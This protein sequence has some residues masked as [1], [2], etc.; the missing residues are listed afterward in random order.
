[1]TDV[2]RDGKEAPDKVERPTMWGAQKSNPENQVHK[3]GGGKYK[4]MSHHTEVRKGE[5]Q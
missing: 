3:M 2:N 5:R 4:M 1:V